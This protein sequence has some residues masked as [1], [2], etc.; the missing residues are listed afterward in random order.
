[1][2]NYI[3]SEIILERK[4][5]PLVYVYIMI[6][7]TI[8]LS[9]IIFFLLFNYKTYY[10]ANGVIIS[11]NN[12]YYIKLYIPLDKL[13]YIINNK[14]ILINKKEYQYKIEKIEGEYF[15]DNINTYQIVYIKGNIPSK[16]KKN[17]LTI[18]IKIQKENKKIINYLIK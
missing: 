12:D 5:K 7:V 18:K 8:I 4:V 13:K 16:Y 3:D 17:N 11:E 15:T 14:K 10:D 2:N 6:I 1:M 9:L